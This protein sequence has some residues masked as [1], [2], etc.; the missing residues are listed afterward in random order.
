MTGLLRYEAAPQSSPP[1]GMTWSSLGASPQLPG[2]T[3][4]LLMPSLSPLMMPLHEV[5]ERS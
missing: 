5:S 3:P 4:S 1:G 2:V